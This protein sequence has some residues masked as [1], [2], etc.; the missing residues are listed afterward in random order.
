LKLL[1]RLQLATT[2]QLFRIYQGIDFKMILQVSPYGMRK[3]TVPELLIV[4]LC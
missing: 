1:Q 2:A 4:W 3:I